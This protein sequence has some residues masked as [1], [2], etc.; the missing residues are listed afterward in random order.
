MKKITL[1]LILPSL[2][3]MRLCAQKFEP[4]EKD[5]LITASVINEKNKPQVGEQVIFESIKTKKIFSGVTKENGKFD[6]LIPKGDKY[7]VKYKA[8]TSDESYTVI[9]VPNTKGELLSFEVTIQFELPKQYT[10]D[11]VLFDSGKA[12]LR[13]ESYKELNEL[14][15]YMHFKKTLVIEI[16]G[17][18]DN[19]GNPDAN[20]KLSQERA[21]TVRDYLIKKGITES[22]VLAKGYGDTQPLASNDTDKGKQ[23]N[24]RTEVRVVKE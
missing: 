3:G 12:T 21:N 22:R 11:N 18:T 5:A 2:F 23:K 1:L 9:D 8:F 7:N 16:A 24:R 14:V 17:H 6:I 13:P 10:L 19:V 15:E 20:L 4:T